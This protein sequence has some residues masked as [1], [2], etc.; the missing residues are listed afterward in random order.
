MMNAR[1]WFG[2]I[3]R[4]VGLFMLV[5]ALLY[6]PSAL[7]AAL[8]PQEAAGH[9]WSSYLATGGVMFI[10]GLYF[11][12]GSPFLERLAYPPNK[13]SRADQSPPV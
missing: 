1:D 5:G 13:G 10:A 2:L 7:I 3:L 11:I 6:V 9:S 12:S 4:V 8:N